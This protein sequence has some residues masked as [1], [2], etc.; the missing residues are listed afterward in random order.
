[1]PR[2]SSAAPAKSR[3]P[4]CSARRVRTRGNGS[5]PRAPPSPDPSRCSSPR[6]CSRRSSSSRTSCRRP[7][8]AARPA[9]PCGRTSGTRR[10]SPSRN[11]RPSSSAARPAGRPSARRRSSARGCRAGPR[12]GRS[13]SN[14]ASSC[15]G[16]ADVERQEDR[17]FEFLGQRLDVRPRLLVQVGDR[18]VGAH[19][20]ER[21]ARSHRRSTSRWRRRRP[22]PCLPCRIGRGSL[23][24]MLNPR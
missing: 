12:C 11:P 17:R 1:M 15:A 16:H 14:T 7:S 20:A 23:T 13:A 5:T 4:G 19:L 3:A 21:L 2:A 18:D 24:V 6:P 8:S 10:P 9:S 22:A